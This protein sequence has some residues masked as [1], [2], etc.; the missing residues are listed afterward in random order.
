MKIMGINIL[1]TVKI[2]IPGATMLLYLM[3]AY[4]GLPA[5]R[6]CEPRQ[7]RK[8]AAVAM[9]VGAGVRRVWVASNLH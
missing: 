4:A 9:D 3:V 5:T 8:G 7:A 2:I 1:F 6:S